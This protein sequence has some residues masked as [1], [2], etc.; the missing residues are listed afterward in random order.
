MKPSNRESY[1]RIARFYDAVFRDRHFGRR[2]A[3][4]LE[5]LSKSRKI[6]KTSKLLDA[7]CGTGNLLAELNRSGWTNL[8]GIDGSSEMLACGNKRAELNGIPMI[9]QGWESVRDWFVQGQREFDCIT[10]LGNS[11]AHAQARQ[12][13]LIL[14]QFFQG[15]APGGMLI[16]DIRDWATDISG[17]LIQSN[18]EADTFRTLSEFNL[19]SERWRAEDRCTYP[20]ECQVIT[21][22]FTPLSSSE[23]DPVVD[24]IPL[25]YGLFNI[26]DAKRWMQYI[27]YD[28]IEACR[29]QTWDY[30]VMV[31]TRP[32]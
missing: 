18:R 14:A 17:Q 7:A 11:L 20:G 26:D 15:L 31:A 28:N 23:R 21:Y 27:G 13:D 25:T 19:G 16:F 8:T 1:A 10:L 9:Y 5:E 22:R 2:Q 30:V 29:P 3:E 4:L 12:V 6:L 32:R 24:E